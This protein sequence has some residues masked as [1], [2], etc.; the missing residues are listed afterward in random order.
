MNWA[1]KGNCHALVS[2]SVSVSVSVLLS[3]LLQAFEAISVSVAV[4]V[5]WSPALVTR[6]ENSEQSNNQKY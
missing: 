5:P 6:L 1:L 3:L 4:L 2:V